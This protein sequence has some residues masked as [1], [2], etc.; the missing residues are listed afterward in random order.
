MAE[1]LFAKDADSA[2]AR[3]AAHPD[4][5]AP[6]LATLTDERFSD[7][8]WIYERKFDGERV[9]LFREGEC[10]RLLT[11]N[12]KDVSSTYP[13]LAEAVARQPL[14]D[15]VADGEVV[16][17]DGKVTSFAR[18]QKRMQIKDADDARASGISVF[19][20]L[21]DLLHVDGCNIEGLPL[22]RRKSLLRKCLRFRDPLRY[23]PHRNETGEKYFQ[24]ACRKGW[25][26]VIA[27]R[28][29]APYRHGRSRDWLKFKCARGQELV[30]GGFTPPDGERKGFGALLLGYYEDG[31]LCYAGKVG[32]G[33][34][35]AFLENF[36]KRLE[37][38]RRQTSPF[39]PVPD[40]TDAM[41]VRPDLVAEIGFTEWTENGKLRHPRFLGLRRDK[42]A[43]DVVR[44]RPS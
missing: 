24:T 6:M 10:V 4:W 22:R 32:T 12:R 42:A 39:A 43:E 31:V 17:F 35:D 18:L 37:S 13:E 14:H 26:G 2:E 1:D 34:D 7:R 9:L 44:E 5:R 16:A 27:K 23:T 3:A 25:E 11:R 38:R 19:Y 21:F 41:W 20:Y 29:D 30:I 36:R 15:F 8:G 40:E 28:A 33:F